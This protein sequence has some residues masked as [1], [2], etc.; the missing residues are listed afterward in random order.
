M[1]KK[2]TE[3]GWP[4]HFI[5]G[6]KCVFNRNTLLEFTHSEPLIISTVGN[7]RDGNSTLSE[8]GLDRYYETMIFYTT[9]EDGY[10]EADVSKQVFIDKKWSIN[11]EDYDS[12]NNIDDMAQKMHED[13]VKEIINLGVKQAENESISGEM[14]DNIDFA[15]QSMMDFLDEKQNPLINPESSYYSM[16]DGVEA[17]DRLEDMF[18]IKEMMIWAKITSFK[19]RLR[20]GKK[21]QVDSQSDIKKILTYEDYYCYLKEK[22]NA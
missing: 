22:L 6:S 15:R 10:I 7:L 16:F 14:D 21:T 18:T 20:V 13:N 5:S 8:I 19:Y 3:R 2:I 4:G 11:R 12:T 9:E 1:I 17:I